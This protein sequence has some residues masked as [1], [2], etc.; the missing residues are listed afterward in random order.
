M[1]R[2]SRIIQTSGIHNYQVSESLSTFMRDF[3]PYKSSFMGCVL[4]TES[5][6]P[7][8]KYCFIK[9]RHLKCPTGFEEKYQVYDTKR[10]MKNKFYGN[11]DYPPAGYFKH[12]FTSFYHCCR[13]DGDVEE[14]IEFDKQDFTAQGFVFIKYCKY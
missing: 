14:E 9:S 7:P 1:R 8:G 13:E 5:E 10:S 3:T 4:K 2:L 6:F 11:G 12:D